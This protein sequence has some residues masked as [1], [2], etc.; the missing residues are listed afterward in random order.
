MQKPLGNL[1][2]N[3]IELSV[4]YADCT[5]FVGRLDVE[6]ATTGGELNI[7]NIPFPS[8]LAV[9]QLSGKTYS[10]VDCTKEV[11]ENSVFKPTVF[12]RNDYF[13]IRS[14]EFTAKNY[15]NKTLQLAL[16][17]QAG[18]AENG[19]SLSVIGEIYAECNPI[20]SRY[21]LAGNLG[22]IPIRFAEHYLPIIGLPKIL[23]GASLL[24]I[25]KMM[26]QPNH[27]GGGLHPMYGQIPQWVRYTLPNCYFHI[28][29]EANIAT[30]VAIMPLTDPPCDLMVSVPSVSAGM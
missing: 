25:T 23:E 28:Q 9:S 20:D 12:F 18:E 11:Y 19:L 14:I 26:G 6:T 4:Q 22:P 5:L 16:E 29:F 21:L 24:D 8:A 3:G 27:Q 1:K 10:S 2:V 17:L 7:R 13:A 15:S 30:Q